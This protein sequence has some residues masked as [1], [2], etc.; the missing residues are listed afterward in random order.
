MRKIT[1]QAADRFH[2]GVCFSRDNTKVIVDG[3]VV[4][5]LL[6]GNCIAQRTP[7]AMTITNC[8]WFTPT[9]KERL[10]GLSNVHITQKKGYWYL[11]GK[12][13]DGENTIIGAFGI[14]IDGRAA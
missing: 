1:E 3:N 2:S 5:M 13:W 10:N 8:G 9:T 11:N 4:K 6:H 7:L 12:L 14:W